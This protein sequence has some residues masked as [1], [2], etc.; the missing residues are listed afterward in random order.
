MYLDKYLMNFAG[1][2]STSKQKNKSRKPENLKQK[3]MKSK[4]ENTVNFNA[5]NIPGSHI[6]YE[7]FPGVSL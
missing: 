3:N 5:E 1:K 7:S 4:K 2:S 6:I